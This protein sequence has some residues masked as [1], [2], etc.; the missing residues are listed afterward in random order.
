MTSQTFKPYWQ[1][2]QILT[3]PAIYIFKNIDFAKKI[4]H[5]NYLN[6]IFIIRWDLKI[7]YSQFNIPQHFFNKN[8]ST[9]ENHYNKIPINLKEENLKTLFI[10]DVL[11]KKNLRQ[12][13]L[14]LHPAPLI[15]TCQQ[16]MYLGDVH[17]N[18]V[19]DA[20]VWKQ[21]RWLQFKYFAAILKLLSILHLN[22]YSII[23]LYK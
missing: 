7:I 16:F 5:K 15:Q 10:K 9:W 4:S 13:R 3:F 21:L 11:H 6:K 23:V 14:F 17:F 19:F 12:L 2:S 1:K 8:Y 22:S 20:I 18:N